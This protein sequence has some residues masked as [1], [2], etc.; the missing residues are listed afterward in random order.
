MNLSPGVRLGPYEILAFVGAGGM[1]EVYRARDPRLGRDIALKVL[2]YEVAA[3]SDRRERL[4]QEA[5]AAAALN[6]PCICTIHEIGAADGQ[7]YI[8]F[9]FIPGQTLKELLGRGPL[10]LDR[11][12]DLSLALGEALEYAHRKAIVHRDLKPSNVIVSELG[13]PK[14][15]DFGVAKV[16]PADTSSNA[17]TA[18]LTGTGVIV[19][20]PGFMSPEQVLGK[21]VDARSDI[22]SF[23]CLLY[24]MATGRPAF[25]GPTWAAV[26]DAVLHTE[27][28][29][30]TTLRPEVPP[31]L[32]R[33]VEKALRKDRVE[34]YQ[35]A[36][37]VVAD[38]RQLKGQG[39][40]EQMVLRSAEE[41]AFSPLWWW[42]LHQVWVSTLYVVLLIPVWLMIASGRPRDLMLFFALVVLAFVGWNLRIHVW[43]TSLTD[44]D[45]LTTRRRQTA[46]L[47]KWND[48]IYSALLSAVAVSVAAS[49]TW[50]AALLVACTIGIL[51]GIRMLEPATTRAAFQRRRASGALRTSGTKRPSKKRR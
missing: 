28:P 15:L 45:S 38:L 47:L 40:R 36:A 27:P 6:H 10:P 49:H 21:A 26:I 35:D 9:E 1:G 30:L 50:G 44:P 39:R 37:G 48:V 17:A 11:L 8:A 42:R 51:Y 2:R 19:G 4:L 23:G 7:Y 20:T 41:G 33:I 29:A 16:E 43:F 5:R 32:P 3:H 14:I 25:T 46:R 12:L 24:E 22:F 13:L 34:R 31:E 18:L